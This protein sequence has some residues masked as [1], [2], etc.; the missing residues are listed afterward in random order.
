MVNRRQRVFAK[1]E[2]DALERSPAFFCYV[3]HDGL[4]E[5]NWADYLLCCIYSF[6][7]LRE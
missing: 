6:F 4:L 7:N 5:T 2:F 1:E 3:A